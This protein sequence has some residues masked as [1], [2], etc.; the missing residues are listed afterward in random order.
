MKVTCGPAEVPNETIRPERRDRLEHGSDESV[1]E[2]VEHDRRRQLADQLPKLVSPTDD[3]PAGALL[4]DPRDFLLRPR[5]PPDDRARSARERH[6]HAPHAAGGAQDKHA[7]IAAHPRQVADHLERGQAG[8]PHRGRMLRRDARRDRG[9]GVPGHDGR[10]RPDSVP[11]RAEPSSGHEH[12][13]PA[14]GARG[15]AAERSRQ[16]PVRAD[17]ALCRI[18]VDRVDAAELEL[19]THLVRARSGQLDSLDDQRLA[20]LMQAGGPHGV[21]SRSHTGS[22]YQCKL[23]PRRLP[24]GAAGSTG[25]KCRATSSGRRP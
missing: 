25:P 20:V 5:L 21:G 16:R 22:I 11:H 9:H 24:S 18:R 1:A 3:H 6:D 8:D 10:L 15:L 19:D 7:I 17:P 12:G 2:P 4:G 23:S 14:V 13:A